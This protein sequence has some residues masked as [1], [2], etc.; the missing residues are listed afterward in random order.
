MAHLLEVNHI[1]TQFKTDGEVVKAVDS[2]SF[3]IDEGEI[4]S[5]VGESGS[6]KS[7]TQMSVLQLIAPPGEIV[8]EEVWLSGE[9]ISDYSSKGKE[10][11]TVRGGKIGMIFQEPMTSLNP[12]MTVGNQIM[13]SVKLHL[14][15]DNT[16]ARQRTLELL[17]SVGLPDVESRFNY[18]P[19]QFSGGMRQRIMIAIALAA[20]PKILIADEATTALD[21]TTQAQLLEMLKD[22]VKKTNTALILVTH[23]LGIV[24][25]Y[26]DRIYVLYGGK[27]VEQGTAKD[28]FAAPAHPYTR[29][30]IKAIP[31]L[32]D[33][34]DRVLIPIDGQPPNLAHLP[35]YCSFLPRCEYKCE[36][37][38]QAKSPELKHIEGIHYAACL[39]SIAELNQEEKKINKENIRSAPIKHIAA[40]RILDAKGVC[41]SFEVTKGLFRHHIGTVHALDS[42]DLDIRKGET[43]GLVGESG[44][45]KSTLA[46]SILRMHNIDAGSITF[47]GI[48]ITKLNEKKLAFLRPKLGMIFQDPFSSLDPR[49]TVGSIIGEPLIVNRL[50]KNRREYEKRVNELFEMVNLNPA[51]K[52]RFPH[53]FSGGQR[54]RVGIARALASNPSLIIC[55]EPISALDVSIQAQII[56]LLEDLQEKLGLSYLFIAHDISVVKHISDRIVV[57]YLGRVVEVANCDTLY[58]KPMHPYTRALFAA[59]PIPDPFIEEKRDKVVLR[60]EVPSI[61]SRPTGCAFHN[62]CE[63]ATEQCKTVVPTLL[64]KEDG[65]QVACINL[66]KVLKKR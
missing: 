16:K 4:V 44:C 62:R 21:V 53:E 8:E 57:M 49:D 11:C 24:A 54:Q 51:F 6:G 60:G 23:N 38:G 55:D 34:K 42:V 33:R 40:E 46:K 9:K 27:I 5:F 37:C 28:I 15:Y 64:E 43:V 1:R 17:N 36:S 65:H 13:E 25:R 61:M 47:E 58:E 2:V 12:V 10:I 45:G 26:T 7:V 48:N 32:D 29:G 20:N 56:N 31:R 41:K 39:K 50:C 22:I 14:Q 18:Y 35:D 59:I 30:L 19:H 3:Y 66:D 63:F 52:D